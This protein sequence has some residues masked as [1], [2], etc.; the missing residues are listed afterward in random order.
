MNNFKDI[1]SIWDSQENDDTNEIPESLRKKIK[2][3]N[4]VV[5]N[6]HAKTII[7]LSVTAILI[8][9]GYFLIIKQGTFITITGLVAMLSALFIRIGIEIVSLNRKKKLDVLAT[10]KHLAKDLSNYYK[11]RK[12]IHK[13]PT[14]LTV[15][16]YILGVGLLFVEFNVHLT[17]FWFNF[18]LIEFVVIMIVLFF[19]IR[20]KIRQEVN[21]LTELVALYEAE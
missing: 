2:K 11:W 12:K 21:S 4:S 6:S 16:A 18:F 15:S 17:A 1:Q 8:T 7:I 3:A 14:I 10:S 5:N 13:F 9:I 19:F 20:K